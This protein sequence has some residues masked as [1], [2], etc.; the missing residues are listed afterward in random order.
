MKP[1]RSI[2]E[3]LWEIL[4]CC[5]EPKRFTQIIQECNLNTIKAKK[6]LDLLLKKKLLEKKGSYFMTTSKGEE[7]IDLFNKLY[8]RIFDKPRNL[9]L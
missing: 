3:T 9:F 2:Y 5:R 6:Y 7:Y 8:E 4:R 1:R